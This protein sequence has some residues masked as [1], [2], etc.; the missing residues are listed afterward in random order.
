MCTLVRTAPFLMLCLQACETLDRR[1][2]LESS[3][4][5]PQPP[6]AVDPEQGPEQEE[7]PEGGGVDAV[8]ESSWEDWP[9]QAKLA[10]VLDHLRQ[11]Y[12]YCLYCGCQV[13]LLHSLL[14][15]PLACA[16][17]FGFAK[18]LSML[19]HAGLGQ[20][21]LLTGQ[22]FC[23]GCSSATRR[24]CCQAVLGSRRRTTDSHTDVLALRAPRTM[25]LG[26]KVCCRIPSLCCTLP[27]LCCTCA[28]PDSSLCLFCSLLFTCK[29]HRWFMIGGLVSSLVYAV[30]VTLF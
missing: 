29:P 9:V 21:T 20:G 17:S 5:W 8:D 16:S 13:G 15:L 4:L 12:S 3:Q 1:E 10:F 18:A 26:L 2:G 30:P 23:A 27:I 14:S 19:R 22:V 28:S 25:A 7:S 24:I 6:P 11:T